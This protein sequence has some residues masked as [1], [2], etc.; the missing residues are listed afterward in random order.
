M[1]RILVLFAKDWDR[2][3]FGR[4][5]YRGRYEFLFEGFDLFRF[6]ENA[7]LLVFDVFSYVQPPGGAVPARTT[8]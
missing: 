2:L 4:P 1:K 8:R 5:E 6:P 7:Q 3:E